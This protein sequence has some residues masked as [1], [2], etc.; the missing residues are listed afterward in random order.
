MSRSFY[1]GFT[2]MHEA[3][4][5]R[6]VAVVELLLL[7]QRQ[8]G[9]GALGR[10]LQARDGACG[11]TPLKATLLTPPPMQKPSPGTT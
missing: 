7:H 9:D 10:L 3:V 8:A 5:Q 4:R 6:S 1:P 2:A 11:S